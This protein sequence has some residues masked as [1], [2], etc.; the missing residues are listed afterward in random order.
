MKR[1]FFIAMF[2]LSFTTIYAQEDVTKFL[3]IPVDGFK[4]DMIKKLVDKGYNT[5]N[6]D[7]NCLVGEFNGEDVF[8]FIV[9]NNNKVYRI[10]IADLNMRD[11]AQ[12]KIRFNT[13]CQQFKNNPKYARTRDFE[14]PE[15]E[16]IS[17]EMTV[18]EKEYHAI[19]YQRNENGELTEDMFNRPVWFIIGKKGNK[20]NIVLYYDNEYNKA[21]GEDL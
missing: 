15:H 19:F 9:T 17:H 6:E 16:D 2:I 3:G 1:L 8:I 11:E 5:F 21:N 12:I 13:L 4:Q 20:Y 14:I 18:N 10:M 7:V